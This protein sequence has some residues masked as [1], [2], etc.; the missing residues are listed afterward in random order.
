ME[1]IDLK[2]S[3]LYRLGFF[4]FMAAC[5]FNAYDAYTT[6]V[7]AA[8][9]LIHTADASGSMFESFSFLALAFILTIEGVGLVMFKWMKRTL[10]HLTASSSTTKQ[11]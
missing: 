2:G 4:T 10:A 11:A 7:Q 9:G 6:Y 3:T 8:V 5:L 1:P